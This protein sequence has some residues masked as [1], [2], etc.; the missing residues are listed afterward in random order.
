M[1]DTPITIAL[2]CMGGDHGPDV[3][4]PA[5]FKALSRHPHLHLIL[6]GQAPVIEEAIQAQKK[7]SDRLSIQNATEIVGM[8]ELPSQALRLSLIHI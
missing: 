6:V 3:T 7:T 2:D 5:A 8:D 1:T 4:V